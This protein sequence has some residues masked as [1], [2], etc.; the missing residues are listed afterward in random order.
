[1]EQRDRLIG[2]LKERVA[3][4]EAE[5][6]SGLELV[7]IQRGPLAPSTDGTVNYGTLKQIISNTEGSC[8]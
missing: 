7:K 3:F 5:P 4:L 1:M 6:V 8:K 2:D